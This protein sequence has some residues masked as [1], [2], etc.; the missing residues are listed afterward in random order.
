MTAVD[1]PWRDRVV[2]VTFT[3]DEY[4]R[5]IDADALAETC[6]LGA[7]SRAAVLDKVGLIEALAARAGA[8]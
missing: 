1:E 5:L 7:F 3:T 2:T 6:D 4:R 8:R